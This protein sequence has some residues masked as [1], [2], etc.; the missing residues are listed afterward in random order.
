MELINHGI[1]VYTTVNV[2]NLESLHDTVASITGITTWNRIPDSIF[3]NA[4]Q[5]ELIDIEP[6]EL[7]ER[8]QEKN[9]ADSKLTVEQLT[10]LREIALR[11]CADRVKR[12]SSQLSK[13]N[14]FHTDEHILACLSSAPSNAKIIR[15]AARMARAFNSQFTAL[16]VETP[17]FAEETPE[18]KERLH[19]HIKLAEQLGANIETIYGDDVPYQIAEY[20]RL[21]GITKIVLGRSAMTRKRFFGKST[22]T[23]QL[24]SYDP[25]MDIHIIPDLCSELPYRQKKKKRLSKKAQHFHKHTQEQCHPFRCH[26]AEH[27]I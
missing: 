12:L 3:D 27:L 19:N 13:T 7:I 26:S 10:A 1:D 4:D 24:L 23:E 21:S 17:D 6:Q 20:A 25:E 2:S 18:N 9:T 8:L 16:F 15:T 22:L 11:R 5:V 14:N